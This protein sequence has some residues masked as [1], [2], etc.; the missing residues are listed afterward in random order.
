MLPIIFNNFMGEA[1]SP[2]PNNL[3][4][5]PLLASLLLRLS[6]VRALVATVL[7]MLRFHWHFIKQDRATIT[8]AANKTPCPWWSL[9]YPWYFLRRLNIIGGS[10]FIVVILTTGFSQLSSK[11]A[12]TRELSKI[13]CRTTTQ[14]IRDN[15]RTVG[16]TAQC[17]MAD[18]LMHIHGNAYQADAFLT[19]G[20]LF[21][22]SLKSAVMVFLSVLQ[23]QEGVTYASA[24]AEQQ[25]SDL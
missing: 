20:I 9:L 6:P 14:T 2:V 22:P 24:S 25:A 15:S 10:I 8:A 18:N 3:V 23:N 16:G 5:I 1:K 12:N 7:L 13:A 17:I 11:K 19:N 21:P 4:L